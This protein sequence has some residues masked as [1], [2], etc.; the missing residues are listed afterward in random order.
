MATKPL[1]SVEY[2]HQCFTYDPLEPDLWWKHRPREHFPDDH[3]W[4][5]WTANFAGQIAGSRSDRYVHVVV[6]KYRLYAHRVI[7]AMQTGAWPADKIDHA[8]QN[9]L[10]NRWANLREATHPKTT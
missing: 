3:I 1:P 10:N 7:W 4:R 9:K 5:V 8:D 6:N 2:L